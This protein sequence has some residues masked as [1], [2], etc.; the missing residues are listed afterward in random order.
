VEN[1]SRSIANA[2]VDLNP[3]QVDA[4]LF[5]VRSPFTKGVLLADEVGLG[6]TIE[7]GIVIAQRWAERKRRI[8]LILPATLRKQWQQEIEEKFSIPTTILESASFNMAKK[9]G[10]PNPFDV[11]NRIVICSYHF[12]AAKAAELRR[13]KWDLVV[14]DEAHRLRNVYKPQNKM[15]NAIVE[16][17]AGSSTLLLT[18]TPLQNSLLELYGLVSVIDPHVFG[19]LTSFREQFVRGNGEAERNRELKRRLAPICR[20]TLRKQVLE[21]IRFTQRVPITQDFLPTEAEHKLY[22][23][24]SAYLQREALHALPASQR[25]LMTLILRKLLASFISPAIRASGSCGS[26]SAGLPVRSQTSRSVANA[27]PIVRWFRPRRGMRTP[28]GSA[29]ASAPGLGRFP[30]SNAGERTDRFSRIGS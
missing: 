1:L 23:N 8:L 10:S 18:A 20:R 11:K 3:H 17:I 7:A 14:V 27:G 22:E 26:T 4:A 25:T 29:G 12:A 5:A 30:T 13:Q 6:K 16:A 24:V 28:S 21:Y 9:S 2:R 15:A 19:D